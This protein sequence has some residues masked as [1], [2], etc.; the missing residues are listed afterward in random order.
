RWV[1]PYI[2]AYDETHG[3]YIFQGGNPLV[4]S[5]YSINVA[6]GSIISNPYFSPSGTGAREPKY[7]NTKDTL[8][9]LYWNNSLSEFF[10]AWINPLTGLYTQIGTTPIAGL[11]GT[12]QGE[13]AYDEVNHRYFAL[14]NTQL[15]CIDAT[16]GNLISNPIL[17]SSPNG[18]LIHFWYDNSTNT[19]Y[20]LM[21]TIGITPQLCYLVSIN[22]STGVMTTVGSGTTFGSGGGSS[23]ID[24]TNQRYMYTYS[25]GGS[26]FHIVTLDIATG[27]VIANKLLPLCNGDNIH[28][29]AFDNVKGKLYGIQWDADTTMG[30]LIVNSPT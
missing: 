22:T 13:T 30:P 28:S 26:S 10:L 12:S 27:N 19:L 16:N 2:R 18:Q 4:D 7:D 24:R 9:G 5:L 14:D 17:S 20:G 29:I 6:N 11:S 21:Q 25:T 23:A 3:A 15:F 1:Y 8:Y